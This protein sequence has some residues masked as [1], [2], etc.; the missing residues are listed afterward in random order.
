MRP[1]FTLLFLLS[2]TLSICFGGVLTGPITNPANGHLYYLLTAQNWNSAETE[3]LTLGGHLVTINDAV[4][5]NWVY[6]T[7]SAYGGVNRRIMIGLTDAAVEGTFVWI[8]GETAT[9]RNWNNGEPNNASPT[10]NQDYCILRAPNESNPGLWN[11]VAL[12]ESNPYFGVVE[13]VPSTEFVTPTIN[14]AVELSWP[15]Q[16]TKQYQLQWTLDLSPPTVWQNLGSQ[17]SGTG[18]TTYYLDSI[19]GAEKRFYRV[20]IITP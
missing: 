20:L 1:L 10:L 8:S 7:F 3:A 17:S 9:Y 13:V 14:G 15:T 5:H 12:S 2:S 11:D 4:E 19:R 18:S 16:T 6:S